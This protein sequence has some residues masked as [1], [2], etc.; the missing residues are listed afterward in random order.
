MDKFKMKSRF[1][2]RRN[3]S[4]CTE[5]A[6]LQQC[7]DHPE[8]RHLWF[9]DDKARQA[10]VLC[11][12]TKTSKYNRQKMLTDCSQILHR[13]F[14]VPPN[15][16][17]HGIE[18]LT[19]QATEC[20]AQKFFRC[21]ECQVTFVHIQNAVDVRWGWVIPEK[22]RVRISPR[23]LLFAVVV[24]EVLRWEFKKL[25]AKM[26][27]LTNVPTVA[28]FDGAN[29]WRIT[30][31]AQWMSFSCYANNCI[32]ASL[33]DWPVNLPN[34]HSTFITN[35]ASNSVGALCNRQPVHCHAVVFNNVNVGRRISGIEC[36]R[37]LDWSTNRTQLVQA[38][39]FPRL[40]RFQEVIK[41]VGRI[42]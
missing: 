2:R 40:K 34:V 13:N 6:G 10:A 20:N 21:A 16:R 5:E 23:V 7:S 32:R 17:N 30:T 8:G 26:S 3:A 38:I 28:A 19:F 18:L 11:L 4:T 15:S 27:K 22:Q 31:T 33:S 14:A 39:N 24:T 36:V 41:M 1:Q 25:I 37:F 42:C 12:K 29:Q 35:L 9:D